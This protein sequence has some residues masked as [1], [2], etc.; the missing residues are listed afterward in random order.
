VAFGQLKK[1]FAKLA[2]EEQ[3]LVITAVQK[4]EG[5]PASF[6]GGAFVEAAV[7]MTIEGMYSDPV[8]GGNAGESGWRSIGW[9]MQEPRP[10]S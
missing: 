7:I 10:K 4:G 5:A 2:P 6:D 3:D 9:T 8:Y 1:P